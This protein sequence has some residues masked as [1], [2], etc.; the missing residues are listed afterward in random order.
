MAGNP[1][2]HAGRVVTTKAT[3]A[4]SNGG[5]GSAERTARPNPNAVLAVVAVAQFR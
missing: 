5:P 4:A 3:A 1:L 2:D